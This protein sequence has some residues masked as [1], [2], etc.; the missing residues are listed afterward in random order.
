MA[1]RARRYLSSQILIGR[2]R[3]I[4]VPATTLNWSEIR[5]WVVPLVFLVAAVVLYLLESSFATT[6]E[7]EIAR[8]AS[9]RDA[10]QHRNIQLAAEIA[11]LEKPSRI[12]E[13]AHALG[14][15]DVAKSIRL[16]V[17]PS[18]PD[19]DVLTLDS[20]EPNNL[21]PAQQ[22]LNDLIT[23]LTQIAP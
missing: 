1:Q 9:E 11:E 12:R 4:P 20:A 3:V 19:P 8:L 14:F 2:Q 15:V 10:I 7:L 21:S 22:W 23:W 13:R 6:S 18:A 16:L 17:P 5:Q